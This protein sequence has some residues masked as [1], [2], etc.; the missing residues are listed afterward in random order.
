MKTNDCSIARETSLA[1]RT[2]RRKA[3]GIVGA[4]I[5]KKNAS[6]VYEAMWWL[7]SGGVDFSDIHRRDFDI[8][9]EKSLQT[10]VS[11]LRCYC[12]D[13]GVDFDAMSREAGQ[14]CF[15]AGCHSHP[16][17]TQ[18][19]VEMITDDIIENCGGQANE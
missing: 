4:I 12:K 18:S 1:G 14:R 5:A 19:D 2:I 6:P 16:S 15:G 9:P 17:L 3:D 11:E 7:D 10:L 13:R 8:E